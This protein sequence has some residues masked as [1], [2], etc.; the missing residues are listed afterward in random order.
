MIRVEVLQLAN[1]MENKKAEPTVKDISEQK[2]LS[3]LSASRWSVVS[4]EECV[5][6]NLSYD[7][8]AKKLN[9]L[10]Q[11]NIAGLC[12][13]SDEAAERIKTISN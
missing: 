13:V 5:A 11:Q 9:E 12:I 10:K 8:A 6:N 7:E 1:K 3:E 4:F 2:I